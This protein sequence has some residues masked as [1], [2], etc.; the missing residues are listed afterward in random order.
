M[1]EQAALAQAKYD[2]LQRAIQSLAELPQF[3]AFVDEVRNMRDIAMRE[4]CMDSTIGNDGRVK[5]ALGEV[6][7]FVSILDLCEQHAVGLTE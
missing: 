5:A 6:R 3:R 2:N 7:A 4:A 1:N